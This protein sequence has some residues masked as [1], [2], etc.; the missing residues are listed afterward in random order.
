MHLLLNSKMGYGSRF[1]LNIE[2]PF[3]LTLYLSVV[4]LVVGFSIRHLN[5]LSRLHF[6]VCT[7][8][9]ACLNLYKERVSYHLLVVQWLRQPMPMKRPGKNLQ[10]CHNLTL[11]RISSYK[12]R[13]ELPCKFSA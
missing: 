8:E 6:I 3:Q 12:Q 11:L 10:S 4:V 9:L 5:V 1:R 2:F 7:R 13:I